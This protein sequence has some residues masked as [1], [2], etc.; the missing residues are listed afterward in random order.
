MSAN[1]LDSLTSMNDTFRCLSHS[2]MIFVEPVTDVT[3]QMSFDRFGLG[4]LGW[5][6]IFARSCGYP[7][8]GLLRD[9]P[10]CCMRDSDV[11]KIEPSVPVRS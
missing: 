4:S 2:F 7:L 9:P 11:S 1:A 10:F 8:L 3:A 5:A 6:C